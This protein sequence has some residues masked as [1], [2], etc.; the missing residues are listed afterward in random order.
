MLDLDDLLNGPLIEVFGEN[1]RPMYTPTK[2]APG[3]PA[4]PVD[5]IFSR[6]HEIV[7]EELANSELTGSGHST[8]V[9]MLSVQ[10][11][12]FAADPK[13]GDGVVIAGEAFVVWNAPTDGSGMIDLILR[14][15]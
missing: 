10:R 13:Q 8:T 3:T 6:N 15:V 7:L 9:P 5:G 1:M 4:F 12:Q 14:K 2:S 11:A